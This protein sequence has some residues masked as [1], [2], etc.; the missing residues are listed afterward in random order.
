MLNITYASSL[1]HGNSIA[2]FAAFSTTIFTGWMFHN[3]SSSNSV[4]RAPEVPNL[5][6]LCIPVSDVAGLRRL[7]SASR[8]LLNFPRCNMS[9]YSR[10]AFSVSLILGPRSLRL[11]LTA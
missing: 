10:R 6:E 1:S 9:N 4:L 7:R 11:E 5:A 2:V 3:V 8:G